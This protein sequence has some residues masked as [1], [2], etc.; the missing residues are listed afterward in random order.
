MFNINVFFSNGL[1][2]VKECP[3]SEEIS[4]YNKLIGKIYGF[5]LQ[6]AVK[7]PSLP[8]FR[9]ASPFATVHLFAK[10]INF[11]SENSTYWKEHHIYLVH[12]LAIPVC[13]SSGCIIIDC[14]LATPQLASFLQLFLVQDWVLAVKDDV[15]HRMNTCLWNNS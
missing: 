4:F 6:A 5:D 15:S 7:N 9:Q 12:L 8:S 2:I 1:L 10:W 14:F 3:L 11:H 13:I